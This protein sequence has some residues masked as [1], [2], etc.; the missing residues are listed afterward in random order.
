MA[1]KR[2]RHKKRT[3]KLPQL[4]YPTRAGSTVLTIGWRDNKK[5]L[6]ARRTL[7]RRLALVPD[8]KHHHP[9]RKGRP[10]TDIYGVTSGRSKVGRKTYNLKFARPSIL[11]LCLR[12][13]IRR[14]IMFA[15]GMGGRRGLGRN[16]RRNL[17][18]HSKT[19]CK[20]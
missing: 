12:R 20:S 15:M 14:E 9:E 2:R 16:K 3:T 1:K 19:S 17:N 13:S 18:E 4:I 10:L 8:L 6:I 11:T 7:P 5:T